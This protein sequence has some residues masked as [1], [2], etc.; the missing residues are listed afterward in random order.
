MLLEI[1][2][3]LVDHSDILDSMDI[4]DDSNETDLIDGQE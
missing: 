2:P 3:D 1:V 4:D